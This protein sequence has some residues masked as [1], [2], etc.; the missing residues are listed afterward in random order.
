MIF[1]IATRN[2]AYDLAAWMAASG[3]VTII[4]NCG[5]HYRVTI[6]EVRK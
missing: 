6:Q 1:K 3:Y 2:N 5:D 4:E